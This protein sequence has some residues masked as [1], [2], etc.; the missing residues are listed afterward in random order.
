MRWFMTSTKTLP[1]DKRGQIMETM[2][3]LGLMGGDA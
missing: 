1:E 3:A 2:H